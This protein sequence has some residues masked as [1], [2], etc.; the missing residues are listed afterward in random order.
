MGKQQNSQAIPVKSPQETYKKKI[1]Y[2]LRFYNKEH[3]QPQLQLITKIHGPQINIAH[4]LRCKPA[5][6]AVHNDGSLKLSTTPKYNIKPA[7]I[8]RK[9]KAAI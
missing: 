5:Y 9:Y 2:P 6:K 1:Y 7:I 3:L 8:G 4:N